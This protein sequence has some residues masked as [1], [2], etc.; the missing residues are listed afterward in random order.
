MINCILHCYK[1][2]YNQT[3]EL[4]QFDS[5][6]EVDY[7]SFCLES[8]T[9]IKE[10]DV[11]ILITDIPINIIKV[12]EFNNKYWYVLDIE[13]IKKYFKTQGFQNVFDVYCANFELSILKQ[14]I[15][16]YKIFINYPI[17]LCDINLFDNSTQQS[18]SSF[19]LNIISAKINETEFTSLVS[20]VQSKG[21]SIWAK[22]S[23]L[24][25][26]ADRFNAVDKTEWLLS[27]SENFINDLNEKYLQFFSFDRIKIIRPKNEI[28]SYSSDINIS[29]ESLFWLIGNLDVL[30]PTIS[31]NVNKI[32]VNNRLFSPLEILSSELEESTDTNEN[33]I[34]HGF[35]TEL[36]LFLNQ[37]LYSF[38]DE[39]KKCAKIKFEDLIVFYSY[40]RSISRLKKILLNLSK[41]KFYLNKN[42]PVKSETLD[43]LNT[44]KI[45]SKEHYSYVYNSLIEWLLY[46]DATFSK[47]KKLFKGINRMDKLFERACFF[48]LIDSFQKLEYESESITFDR[49]DFPNKVKLSKKGIIHYLYFEI[50]PESLVTVK[51]GSWK[52]KPDFILELENG[53]FVIIDAKYKKTSNISRFDYP[54][55]V[56]KYLH[57]IGFKE[58]GFFNP[59]ALFVL[60]PGTKN[61]ID[62]YQRS[63]YDL[64]S[65]NPI[66]PSIGSV[67]LNFEEESRLLNNSIQ[68]LLEVTLLK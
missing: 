5:I 65:S 7:F 68:K 67:A 2:T 18:I 46:K 32:V 8:D 52:L 50:I 38:E 41:I 34:V 29:E 55:L 6:D 60:F 54:E 12:S 24:K 39:I 31:H 47:D 58:G 1:K 22:H 66:F 33:Q 37:A 44:N 56:L 26:T 4:N 9:E 35:L 21:A 3:L 30:Q 14:E 61:D 45:E 42:I 62:Y 36:A 13:C 49:D 17:G 10:Q 16:F 25:H 27:F 43:Y 59:L 53:H 57:G 48:K 51:K 64:E 11:T 28:A 23:L 63:E 20:F 40:T 19:Y 15:W